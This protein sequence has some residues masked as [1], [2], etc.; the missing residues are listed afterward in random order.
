V[1]DTTNFDQIRIGLASPEEIRKWSRGEVKKPETIN[2]RTF[3][4]EPDGLFCEKIFG[5]TRDWECHCGK[6]RKIKFRG[7]TCDRCGVEVTRAKVRRE[8][9]GHIELAA[10]VAH[11]WYLKNVPSP[12]SLLLDLSPRPLEKVLYFASYIITQVDTDLLSAHAEEIRQAVEERKYQLDETLQEQVAMVEEQYREELEENPELPAADRN[13]LLAARDERV[14]YER[15]VIEDRKTELDNALR[16]LLGPTLDGMPGLIGKQLLTEPDHRSLS[17]LAE[18]IELFVCLHED[19]PNE[20]GSDDEGGDEGQGSG[21]RVMLRSNPR[22]TLFRSQTGADAIK[23]L[24]K[25]IDLEEESRRLRTIIRETTG[26]K[27]V[28][29][30]KQLEVIES[31]RKSK[32][33]PEWMILDAVPVIPP[34]LRP[35]VQLDG[36]RFATSD[37]NDLYRRI[38]NR[39]NRLKK[40]KDL[41]APESIINHEK[42]LLQEAV[43]ALI[44]NGRRSRPVTGSNNRPLKSLSDMLKGKD[45]RFRKNLLGKRVDYSG[46][47]VIVVGPHL[48]LNQC[49]LPKEMALE[50]FKPF[51]MKRLVQK[52]LT[53]NVKTAKKMVERIRPE[54]WDALE[55]VI[56][57]HPVM[58]NRAPTLHRLGIQAFEPVLVDGKAIQLHPLVC[59]AFNADFDGD[60]MAVHVPLSTMAQAEA[61]IL[62]MSSENLFSPAHGKPVMTPTRDMVLGSYYMTQKALPV[63]GQL[64]PKGMG[65]VFPNPREAVLAHEA[66]MVDLHAEVVVRMNGAMT[67]TTVGRI[68][69]NQI[70]PPKLQYLDRVVDSGEMANL[71]RTCYE[72]YG[73]GR[74][75]KLL[76]DLKEIGFKYATLAG[77]TIAMTDMDVPRQD[78]ERIIARTEKAVNETNQR[79]ADG[80]ISEG[81]RSQTVCELWMRAAEEVAQA[82][83]HNIDPFNPLLMMSKS[84][85]RGTI[86]QLSQLAGMRGLMTDPFGRFIEDLPIKSNFHEGLNVLEYFV[87]THG[88]RKGLADTALR[89]ADAGYLTRRM[90]DVAQDVIVRDHDCG[91]HSGIEVAAIRDRHEEIESLERRIDGRTAASDIINPFTGELILRR[92]QEISNRTLPVCPKDA[93]IMTRAWHCPGCETTITEAQLTE[94]IQQLARAQRVYETAQEGT[95]RQLSDAEELAARLQAL[96]DDFSIG[97][98]LPVDEV[99]AADTPDAQAVTDEQTAADPVE[100]AAIAGADGDVSTDPAP[101]DEML[102][103]TDDDEDDIVE[104]DEDLLD[105][106]VTPHDQLPEEIDTMSSEEAE[107][108]A[109]ALH[110][111][112]TLAN[113]VCPHCDQT[114]FEVALCEECGTMYTRND[115]ESPLSTIRRVVADAEKF[116]DLAR[117]ARA[118][119]PVPE[120]VVDPFTGKT[121]LPEGKRA[122][123]AQLQQLQETISKMRSTGGLAMGR[124]PIRSSLV[125]ELRQ[126]ICAM[127]YGRDMA[128]GRSVEVGEAVGIIAAQ[129]IGEPGTQ[130]TMRTFHTGGV[131]GQYLTGVANVKEQRVR[132][133]QQILDDVNRG[134]VQL[135]TEISERERVKQIQKMVK[136]MEQQVSGLLRVVELF[137]ARKPKG[138]AIITDVDG[139]VA[140]IDTLGGGRTVVLHSEL[141]LQPEENII[142]QL[143]GADIVH[144]E[145]GE[146]MVEAGRELTPPIVAKLRQAGVGGVVTEHRYMV[147]YRGGL[148]VD[149]SDQLKAGNP[150]TEGPL[151]PQE[152]LRMRGPREVQ[153]YLVQEIQRVYRS[154]GVDINDKHVEVIVRQMLRRRKITEAG[155]TDFLPG[156]VIDRFEFERENHRVR[157]LGGVEAQADWVLLGITEASLATDSFLSAASFQKTT[158]VLTEA[159]IKGKVDHLIGLKENVIIGRLIPAGTGM[160]CYRNVKVLSPG[161]EIKLFEPELEASEQD[162]VERLLEE[163]D[164]DLRRTEED[165]AEIAGAFGTIEGGD[166]EEEDG[167][168]MDDLGLSSL[169]DFSIDD[170]PHPSDDAEI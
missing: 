13:K 97:E 72:A 81:E 169:A 142:G 25:Q 148:R 166:E 112:H 27:R 125:C 23:S 150:L 46:R 33:R 104:D 164:L 35:M 144:P 138:Q 50:L 22:K 41:R 36:G 75:V 67:N 121:I 18:E 45:G 65:K 47:S 56:K 134:R 119:L 151:D 21:V 92:N 100:E 93:G 165:A 39:N 31:F 101:T 146:V 137:E 88:A 153:E 105:F 63:E 162:F 152:L 167:I 49:G 51:V 58:L 30:V 74:T 128:T 159:A 38:I 82:M 135:G 26:P 9:M 141:P 145:T 78:R 61:R 53:N 168:D 10:P 115:L 158:R 108:T 71:V 130:L 157:D 59:P 80:I 1:V 48:K 2:Y 24:L 3:K 160:D 62:M 170:E 73:H 11:I 19:D 5:P 84:G 87:S 54:V 114:L 89:T 37:L 6:Y 43:D 90:V 124:V 140:K 64:A 110:L 16:L 79:F 60:Q 161:G 15:K 77:I 14:A 116:M 68:I 133:L 139:N 4:P 95:Q 102:L 127:C 98:E 120:P 44:D 118:N 107:A 94:A 143:L 69:F 42:R 57:D 154:Q 8:R 17:N 32:N 106:A 86:R 52:G 129:S 66:G 70:L 122:T 12:M 113:E 40:I 55:E 117:R 132:T 147:P 163:S 109:W 83:L 131:A 99:E 34:E 149:T 29:A 111:E 155:D 91:T 126:G 76:D 20:Y 156:Q 103:P 123:A 96:A 136:V 85:A 7:I 28:R